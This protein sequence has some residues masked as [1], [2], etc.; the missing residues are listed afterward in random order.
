MPDDQAR[1]A[2]WERELRGDAGRLRRGDRG[3]GVIEAESAGGTEPE[4]AARAHAERIVGR[5]ARAREDLAPGAEMAPPNLLEWLLDRSFRGFELVAHARIGAHHI[6]KTKFVGPTTRSCRPDGPPRPAGAGASA[7]PRWPG[8]R[9][10]RPGRRGPRPGPERSDRVRLGAGGQPGRD[11]APDHPRPA[12]SSVSA[13]SPCTRRP[14]PARST[15]GRR[16][17]PAI[18]PAPARESYL[19]IERVIGAAREAR[20][21]RRPPGLRVPLGKLAVR[22]SLPEGWSHLRRS[23]SRGA[24]DDGPEDG[25]APARRPGR[26]PGAARAP[27]APSRAP[28]RPGRSPTRSATRSC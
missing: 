23:A 26:R 1:V 21:A 18:G 4:Q 8:S 17:A 6:F 27:T 28:G 12:G 25:S 19:S 22:R 15:S 11:R 2:T 13:R 10:R 16:T 7:R 9:A 3:R 24:A 5:D 20:V 14:M